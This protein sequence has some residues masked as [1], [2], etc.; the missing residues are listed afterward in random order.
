ME[1][2]AGKGSL[3]Q[4][5]RDKANYGCSSSVHVVDECLGTAG[6]AAYSP[7]RGK[8]AISIHGQEQ[9]SA[10]S[11]LN[12]HSLTRPVGRSLRLEA[13][14]HSGLGDEVAWPSRIV[15]KLLSECL[16]VLT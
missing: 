9:R 16:D 12:D 3:Q 5:Q 7:R 8:F 13:V 10:R 6:S 11:V 15:F 1:Q 4:G 2:T 14:A